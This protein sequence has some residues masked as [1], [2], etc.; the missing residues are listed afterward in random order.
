MPASDNLGVDE[1]LVQVKDEVDD[2]RRVHPLLNVACQCHLVDANLV[3]QG[4]NFVL[5]AQLRRLVL[6]SEVDG[7]DDGA[8]GKRGESL[9]TSLRLSVD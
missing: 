9:Y 2:L 1:I 3:G 6:H 4:V 8:F 7:D 5:E